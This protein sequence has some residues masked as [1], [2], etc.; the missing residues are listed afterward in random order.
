MDD[1]TSFE[2][3]GATVFGPAA[4]KFELMRFKL[5]VNTVEL[6]LADVSTE[7]LRT[8]HG[9]SFESD[10]R[11]GRPLIVFDVKSKAI[12]SNVLHIPKHTF[13][14]D[15]TVL[16]QATGHRKKDPLW[17]QRL[18]ARAKVLAM[19]PQVGAK[20][21]MSQR[22]WRRWTEKVS[23]ISHA[24][25]DVSVS[26]TANLVRFLRSC[27]QRLHRSG[28]QPDSKSFFVPTSVKL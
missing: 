7:V 28:L 27:E 10:T 11:W 6:L 25:R 5:P 20:P 15:Q 12:Y 24:R 21:P 9:V 1:S 19:K 16:L 14:E 26:L 3:V 17:E 13:I 8:K 18:K 22:E 2:I 23:L 4:L